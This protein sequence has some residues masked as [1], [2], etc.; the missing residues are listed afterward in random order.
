MK[1]P[2]K[3]KKK[4]SSGASETVE[5]ESDSES[6]SENDEEVE[7][8][9]NHGEKE[10]EYYSEEQVLYRWVS[11]MRID[12]NTK[13]RKGKQSYLDRERIKK[14]DNINFDWE[15]DKE[16]APRGRPGKS[17]EHGTWQARLEQLRQYKEE[18]GDTM[19]PKEW[20][21]DKTLGHWVSTQRKQYNA[22]LNGDKAALCPERIQALENLGFTWC[23]RPWMTKRSREAKKRER[24]EA[25]TEALVLLQ[26]LHDDT[27]MI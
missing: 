1:K 16:R 14:L 6:D 27:H 7:G 12:Y 15:I 17:K 8:E 18:H 19:V 9:G 22:L 24:A 26:T 20:P 5:D 2:S 23:V 11:R 10:G 3:K 21:Q 4:A 25:E 13:Y